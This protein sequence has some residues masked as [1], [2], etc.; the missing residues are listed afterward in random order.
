MI[1][2][3][4]ILIALILVTIALTAVFLVRPSLTSGPT[5]K[6]LA[7][8][9][10]CGL[11]VICI[12]AGFSTQMQRSEQ[13]R[14]C[15]TC[16]SMETHGQSLYVD[17]PKYLAAAH[18][19]NHRVPAD[20]ACYACHTDYTIYGPVKDKLQGMKR[21]YMQYVSTPP[22]T[23]HVDGGYKNFE[24]L[25]C[26]EGARSFEE[27]PVHV[28]IKDSLESNQIS[29]ISSGC[30]DTVHNVAALGQVKFWRPTP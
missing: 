13:T 25:H 7:F 12:G 6:I 29:C 21:I 4:G 16:H 10:L 24:C 20:R 26:H 27:F 28:A 3:T 15:I 1:G 14:F 19:Q 30:H 2:Q 18:F 11:P 22:K 8:V 17:D 23:L 9:S 5:G